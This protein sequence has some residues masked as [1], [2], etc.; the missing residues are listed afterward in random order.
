MKKYLPGLLLLSCLALTACAGLNE[1]FDCPAPEG[2]SCKRM[3]QVYEMVNGEGDVS[4]KP[5]AVAPSRNPLIL[6]GR[7]GDPL[8]YG[9]GVMRL[10]IAPYED[11]DG[12]YH[13]TN[14]IYSVVR[15]GHWIQNPPMATK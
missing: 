13:Q 12:N 11:R 6:E 14:E 2:G 8:R 1:N 5:L 3:D 4:K 15:E 10:W 7:P 9:E